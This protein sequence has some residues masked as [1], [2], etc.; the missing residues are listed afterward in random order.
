MKQES[1][2][3]RIVRTLRSTSEPALSAKDLADSLDVSVRTVHNHVPDLVEDE[4]IESTQIGNA[5]AY[6]VPFED[7][8]SHKKPGHTCKRCG[9]TTSMYD[10]SKIEMDIYFESGKLEPD[11]ADF[12]IFCRFCYSDFIS[13]SHNDPNAMGEYPRVHLWNIPED[14]LFE[15]RD[16]PDILTWP[17]EDR[18]DE[19][20]QEVHEFVKAHGEDEGM[21][22]P[23]MEAAAED[24][25]DFR[26]PSEPLLDRMTKR[27]YFY[28]TVDVVSMKY[29]AAK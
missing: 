26:P 19:R 18:M 22:I 5:T 20:E 7:L 9:R 8:P 12:H 1:T 15:V 13:W 4:R 28:Q 24:R 16:D 21:T 27:G 25:D 17:G 23:E 10:F 6:Y 2:K 11:T 3:E 29:I 14:Q